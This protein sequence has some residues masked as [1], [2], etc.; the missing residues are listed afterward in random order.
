MVISQGIKNEKVRFYFIG[1]SIAIKG[2]FVFGG[3]AEIISCIKSVNPEEI[4]S[5]IEGSW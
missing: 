3:D 2:V 1:S 4:V 5:Y